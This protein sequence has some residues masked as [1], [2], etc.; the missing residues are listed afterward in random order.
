MRSHVAGYKYKIT[1]TCIAMGC[2]IDSEGPALETAR[3]WRVGGTI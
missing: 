3:N 1:H 2:C